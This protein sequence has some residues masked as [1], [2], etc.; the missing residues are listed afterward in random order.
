MA[1]DAGR[2]G[3]GM[4]PIMHITGGGSASPVL[5]AAAIPT[6]PAHPLRALSDI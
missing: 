4:T 1:S 3:A 6:P 2:I 5:P